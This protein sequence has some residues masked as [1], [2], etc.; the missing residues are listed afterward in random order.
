MTDI[1]SPAQVRTFSDCEVRWFYEHLLGLPDPPTATLA[2]DKAVR[3]AL[4][5]NFRYKLDSKEDIETEGVVGLF[6][7][8]W[9]SQLE[10]AAFCDDEVPEAIGS[11]GEHL[12]RRCAR[13][14]RRGNHPGKSLC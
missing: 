5:A 7:R 12:V 10:S 13:R 4:L 3:A 1:L 2:L 6:R 9:K 11:T 14:T 8:A